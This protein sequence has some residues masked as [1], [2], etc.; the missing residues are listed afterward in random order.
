VQLSRP[1]ARIAGLREERGFT[2]LLALYVLTITTLLL[3]AAY[4][5]VLSDTGL[6]RN[7][8]DQKRAYAAAQAGIQ[9]YDYDVNQNPNYWETCPSPSGTIG[10]ADSGSTE[11]YTDTPIVA[12]TAPGGTTACS[13]SNPIG[14]MIESTS[15][16][17]SGTFRIA[18]TG[19]S[20]NV[21]RTIVAQYKRDSFLNFVYYTDYETLDPAALAG[22]PSDCARHYSD[23]PGRG[24]DCSG[25]IN[26]V[27]ADHI[28]GPL[29]SEDTLA[30]CGTPTFGRTS[31]DSIQA[32][33]LSQEGQS[34]GS[35][36]SPYWGA[37][38]TGTYTSNAPSL[39][40]PPTDGQM[41]NVAQGG[42]TVYT[43][44][45]TI[46]LTG[47]TATVTNANFNG[48]TPTSVN[49]ASTNGVIYVESAQTPVCAEVYSPFTANSDYGANLGCGNVYVSG[50]YNMPLTIASDNDIIIDGNIWP[51]SSSSNYQTST[52]SLGGTPT[53]NNLLGLVANN[54]VRVQHQVSSDRGTTAFS[55]GSDS[56]VTSGPYATV[57]NPYI[58][59]A[60]LA[61]QHSFIVDNYDCGSSP[62]TLSVYGAIAQLFRGPVGSGSGS[63]NTGYAKSY[64]YDD[65]LAYA[66]PPYFL[67]PISVAW[68]VQHETECSA[69]VSACSVP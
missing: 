14:T 68:T 19:T 29:H 42:G 10:S 8:L 59:A 55:C 51:G 35:Y 38:M 26:F 64:N 43:G 54:F 61:V 56:N 44:T 57:S 4:V 52:G 27:S 47:T 49:L 60:I 22:D 69:S 45:T 13:T 33:A 40:P 3:G 17:A 20:N 6:S 50:Y 37:I 16:T 11:S 5:A 41:L 58:Y 18:A 30:I 15:S 48:G 9:Q 32:P 2:M 36:S 21:S 28:N 66:E 65:R 46:A 7:D 67:N 31:A 62:G 25:P 24:S 53:G 12:S 23:S 1:H 34:C 39:L 63:V